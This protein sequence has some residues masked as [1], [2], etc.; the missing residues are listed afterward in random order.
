MSNFE[1]SG[2]KAWSNEKEVLP[3]GTES[4]NW[5]FDYM[6]GKSTVQDQTRSKSSFS[7]AVNGTKDQWGGWYWL[8]A[9]H[10]SY[11]TYACSISTS[12]FM[13]STSVSYTINYTLS[14]CFNLG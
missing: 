14:F 8:R 12:G 1:M 3:G 4:P 6:Y 13:N 5:H 11:A 9:A 7:A 10:A 2:Q